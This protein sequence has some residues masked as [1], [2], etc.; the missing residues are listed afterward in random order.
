[1]TDQQRIPRSWLAFEQ[2]V[3]GRFEL[4]TVALPFT[5][6]PALGL[7]LKR[8]GAQVLAN[9]LLQSAW[10]H[11]V[12]TI[13]NNSERLTDDDVNIILDDAYVPG[14]KLRN[15]SLRGWFSETDA[16]W[17]D[18]V[19]TNLDRIQS[20]LAF[21][22]AAGLAIAVGNY[23]LSFDDETRE[24]RQPL[25]NVY[26]RLWTT[27]PEP[28]NNGRNNNCQNKPAN[29]FISECVAELMF[30]RLPISGIGG[31]GFPEKAVWQEEWLRCGNDFWDELRNAQRGNLGMPVETKSQY[32]HLLGETLQRA[33]HIKSW[34]IAHVENAFVSTQ[35]LIEAISARRSVEA[36]YTKDFSELTGTKAVIITA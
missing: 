5:A 35:E 26:R 2:N 15:S 18:N 24:L 14:N 17:F 6:D 31:R 32:L 28:V 19:R 1:M 9:D 27:F 20:P 29:A 30:L 33:A 36:I 11:A 21:A 34:A 25:S 23:V 8:R 7:F 12:A 13:Q 16:W 10:T 4:D 3:L 22:I